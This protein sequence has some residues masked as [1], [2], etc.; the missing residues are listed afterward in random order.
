MEFKAIATVAT[1]NNIF[2][3]YGSND[4]EIS[5]MYNGD[6]VECNISNTIDKKWFEIIY[7]ELKYNVNVLQ[8]II[9]VRDGLK[10]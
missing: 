10:A 9:E 2:S 3:N 5:S 7:E 8:T 1:V 4:V 6:H